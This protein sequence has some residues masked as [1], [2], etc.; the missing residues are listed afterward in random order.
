MRKDGL[1]NLMLMWHILRAREG[2]QLDTY[3]GGSLSKS[4]NTAK[5]HTR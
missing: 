1:G 4:I 2:R 3:L 5:G